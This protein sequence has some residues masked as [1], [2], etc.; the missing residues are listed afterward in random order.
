MGGR[1]GEEAAALVGINATVGPHLPRRWRV[2]ALHKPPQIGSGR[3]VWGRGSEL[4]VRCGAVR[5]R[6]VGLGGWGGGKRGLEV[7]TGN[8]SGLPVLMVPCC[9]TVIPS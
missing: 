9:S 7:G 8:R 1:A 3:V 2:G 6:E 4:V 5:T